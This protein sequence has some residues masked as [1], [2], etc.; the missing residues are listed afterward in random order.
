MKY[1]ENHPRVLAVLLALLLGGTILLSPRS[2]GASAQAGNHQ[3]FLPIIYTKPP[4]LGEDFPIM[5]G[6]YIDGWLAVQSDIDSRLHGLDD[7]ADNAGGAHLS[8]AATFIDIETPNYDNY[9]TEQFRM[10]WDNGYIPF[11]N[12]TSKHAAYKIARGDFDSQIRS[13]AQAYAAFSQN[14][15]RI[16]FI[17]PL[18]E[19]NGNWTPYGLDPVNFK[20]AYLRIQQIFV[21]EGVGMNEVHWTFAPNG[22]NKPGTPPFEDYY[23]GDD[24]VDVI[25]FSGYNFGTCDGG[26]WQNP[27]TVFGSYITRM[28]NMASDKPIFIAQTASSSNGGSKDQW[29]RDTYAYLK[30]RTNLRAVIY[31]NLD[32]ECD[33]AFYKTWGS[34]QRRLNAYREAVA[35]P[36]YGYVH[37]SLLLNSP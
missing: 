36:A 33:W 34:N 12:M 6:T 17:A 32:K 16:A 2:P 3:L 29:L 27:E 1:R 15:S 19:M 23:P 24:F 30:T 5:L 8:I 7:W 20:L 21:S 14:G 10:A 26:S 4:V 18:Q 37:P 22:W 28:Q 13:W 11:A 25:G 9:V 35:D 31:F